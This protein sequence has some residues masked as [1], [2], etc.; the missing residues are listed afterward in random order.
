MDQ[1][2]DERQSDL[3]L[4]PYTEAAYPNDLALPAEQTAV[5]VSCRRCAG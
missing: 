5:P 4:S 3:G 1:S 2:L